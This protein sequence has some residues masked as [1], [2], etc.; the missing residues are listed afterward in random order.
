MV[1]YQWRRVASQRVRATYVT[2]L[3]GALV[4]SSAL[5]QML[6]P[7]QDDDEVR[8]E[9]EIAAVSP[10]AR[11]DAPPIRLPGLLSIPPDAMVIGPFSRVGPLQSHLP[12]G[13]APDSPLLA[14][15]SLPAPARAALDLVLASSSRP[16]VFDIPLATIS[17]EILLSAVPAGVPGAVDVA[18]G[19]PPMQRVSLSL[20]PEAP[21]APV[22]PALV[23]T[24]YPEVTTGPGTPPPPVLFDPR[25]MTSLQ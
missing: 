7:G 19:G 2:V 5:A 21:P 10:D 12:L 20:T 11:R 17:P 8:I 23:M 1:R 6:Q 3:A 22:E 14:S 24:D 16:P 18:P 15:S 9:A 13:A 25:G 4:S